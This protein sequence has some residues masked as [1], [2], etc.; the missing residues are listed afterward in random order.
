MTLIKDQRTLIKLKEN[1]N[2]EAIQV[3]TT[4]DIF[5]KRFEGS[6]SLFFKALKNGLNSY[7]GVSNR[8]YFKGISGAYFSLEDGDDF[9]IIILYD[10]NIKSLN[11]L[12]VVTRLK[13]LLG[14]NIE[15]AFGTFDDFAPRIYQMLGITRKS[16]TFGDFYFNKKWLEN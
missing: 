3:F 14:L 8:E 12:Q 1:K 15:V 10:T 11:R 16:Q 5:Q 13:K 2:I 7:S 4:S 9:E 6:I